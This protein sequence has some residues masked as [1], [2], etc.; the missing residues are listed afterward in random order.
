MPR[1]NEE[2]SDLWQR[3]LY[4]LLGAACVVLCYL[5]GAYWLGPWLHQ[6]QAQSTEQTASSA[7][8]LLGAPPLPPPAFSPPQPPR[9]QGVQIRERDPATLPDTVRVIP[10]GGAAPAEESAPAEEPA[11]PTTLEEQPATP[12]PPANLWETPAS[13]PRRPVEETA[14]VPDVQIPQTL[15]GTPASPGNVSSATPPADTLYRVRLPLAYESREEADTMLRN[16][17]EKGLPSTVV[18]DTVNG[19]KVFRVQLGVY[20]N[21]TNAEKLA[22]QARQLGVPVEVAAPTR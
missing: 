7:P 18:T 4:V 15:D 10:P 12:P 14:P 21:R 19:R 9:L 11:P 3:V 17:N 5:V 20:R 16:L 22:E 6:R 8:N 2:R 1:A 13:A